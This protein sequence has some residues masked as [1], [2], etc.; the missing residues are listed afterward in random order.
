MAAAPGAAFVAPAEPLSG[1]REHAMS[2]LQTVASVAPAN[3][4]REPRG[5]RRTWAKPVSTHDGLCE[6]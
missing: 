4:L 1:E 3:S 6:C 5:T 2:V